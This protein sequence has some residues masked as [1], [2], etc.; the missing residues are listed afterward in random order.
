[1][2]IYLSGPIAG[3]ANARENFANAARILQENGLEVVDPF[4]CPPICNPDCTQSLNGHDF[5]CWLRGDLLAMLTCD[6]VALLPGWERSRGA[7]L[8]HFVALQ[9]GLLVDN[10]DEW[11]TS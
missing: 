5:E 1:M 6:G 7:R 10:F 11:R 2:K 9:T 3:V 4:N 8:E